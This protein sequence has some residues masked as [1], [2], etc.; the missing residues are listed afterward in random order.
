MS[1][2][3]QFNQ[4]AINMLPKTKELLLN[5]N[6]TEYVLNIICNSYKPVAEM[7]EAEIH[8]FDTAVAECVKYKIKY[9]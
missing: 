9:G 2:Q 3:S 8:I 7:N 1:I 6:F 5:H 4:E